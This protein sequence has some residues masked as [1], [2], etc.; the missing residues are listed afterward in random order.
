M[1]I[2]IVLRILNRVISIIALALLFC[3]TLAWHY[4]ES[5]S[6]L[7]LSSAIAAILALISYL[8]SGGKDPVEMGKREAYVSVSAAWVIISLI[9]ALPYLI[10]GYVPGFVD[11]YFESV[12]GFSTTG[13]SILTDIEALPKSLLFWRSLTHWI[14][15]IGIIMLVIVISPSLKIGNYNL[16]SLESSLKEKI[17]PRLKTMGYRL[18][19]IY[20]LLT[21]AETLLLVAGHMPLFDSVCHA[22]GTVATGGF[23]TQNA[24]IANYSPYIQYVITIFMVLSGTNF[25]I[26][27]YLFRRD[28][29]HLRKNEEFKFYLKVIFI[30]GLV[31]TTILY[32]E[33]P[34]SFE[35]AFRDAFF[36]TVSIITCTGYATSD[37]LLWPG[38]A[39]LLIFIMLFIGGST[40]S[41]AGGI[42]MARHLIAIKNIKRGLVNSIHPKGIFA[43]KLNGI[44]LG[45]ASNNS[46][47]TFIVMY[48]IIFVIGSILLVITG[49][50]GPT[51]TSSIATAMGG[52]G[53]GF[54]TVG[55]MSNFHNLPAV[56][57]LIITVFMLMGRLEI[58]SFLLIFTPFFWKK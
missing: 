31:V 35:L 45:E 24:S 28:F 17:R 55:P 29:T 2:I 1:K 38:G 36:Q 25:I 21:F 56:S 34:R 58:Y 16:F 32:L 41:T 15:G 53:P 27:Y 22:F 40:G 9:G 23:S 48:F 26:H 5:T 51:A 12:S 14:G 30:L 4:H 44:T 10:S 7:L 37:Y 50:D 46:L 18:L 39:S 47:M 43:V 8:F 11:A 49:L 19:L 13:S 54:G 3:V 42:K 52:V 6:P 57:K 20:V 33:T